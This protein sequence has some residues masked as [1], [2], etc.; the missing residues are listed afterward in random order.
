MGNLVHIVYVYWFI[1]I[2]HLA[3][4]SSILLFFLIHIITFLL[5]KPMTIAPR[6]TPTMVLVGILD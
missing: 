4:D 6:T 5:F 3:T 1:I 2:R